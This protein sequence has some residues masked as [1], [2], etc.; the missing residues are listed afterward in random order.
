MNDLNP[1]EIH[2]RSGDNE[3]TL[4]TVCHT[5]SG[6]GDLNPLN[7]LFGH[8]NGLLTGVIEILGKFL[9]RKHQ[10]RR[11]PIRLGNDLIQPCADFVMGGIQKGK[12]VF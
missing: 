4:N 7:G 12:G 8:P 9:Y 11:V 10:N 6:A 5:Q 2:H 3:N 1:L